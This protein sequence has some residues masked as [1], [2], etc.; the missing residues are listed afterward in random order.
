M[1]G[2]PIQVNGAFYTIKKS[3]VI[4]IFHIIVN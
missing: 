3:H 1:L 2:R 4:A